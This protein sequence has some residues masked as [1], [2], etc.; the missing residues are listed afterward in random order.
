M[1]WVV[2]KPG[3]SFESL[4]RRF[5]KAVEKSGVL[6][7][8]RK[9]EFFEKPSVLAKKKSAAARKRAIKRFK[10]T[11]SFGKKSNQN[12]R[13]NKD[14]TQKIPL[15]PQKKKPEYKKKFSN[16]PTNNSQNQNQGYQNRRWQVDKTTGKPRPP[17]NLP[18]R[19]PTANK[20]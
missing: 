9:H 19:Q 10:K 8:A 4:M 14:H 12:F 1:S 5:K 18:K 6:A 20:G 2:A 16:T 7:D 11:E 15:A 17:T 3:E 13:F